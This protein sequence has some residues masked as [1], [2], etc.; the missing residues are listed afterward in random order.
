[1]PD[2]DASIVRHIL[3][4]SGYGR[5]TPYLSTSEDEDVAQRFAGTRGRVYRT[6]P[7]KILGHGIAHIP[8][9]D[10][11]HLL[12]GS[13]KGDARWGNAY[14]V[15]QARRYVEE[16]AEHLVDFRTKSGSRDE[17]LAILV[18]VLFNKA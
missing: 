7:K 11:L 14:E 17:E 5:L 8:Y 15:M 18:K 13:G 3:Y 6:T 2:A 16:N 9:S 12:R 1:M 4:L 10:L